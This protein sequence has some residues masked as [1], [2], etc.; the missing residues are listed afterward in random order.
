MFCLLVQHGQQISISS[1]QC[2]FNCTDR[3]DPHV[4]V[5]DCVPWYRPATKHGIVCKTGYNYPTSMMKRSNWQRSSSEWQQS[6]VL[7]RSLN[8]KSWYGFWRPYFRDASFKYLN[9]V[10]AATWLPFQ[11]THTAPIYRRI[12]SVRRSH[13]L[14]ALLT[15]LE[16]ERR[17]LNAIR[18]LSSFGRIRGS[19]R[20]FSF[21][22]WKH[23]VNVLRATE[24]HMLSSNL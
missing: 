14:Q 20:T 6:F 7:R 21:N 24:L 8:E 17:C 4:P 9:Y 19:S 10:Q 3:R 12:R 2:F 22:V 15:L 5:H 18:C 16:A 11:D 1:Q 13:P 23:K